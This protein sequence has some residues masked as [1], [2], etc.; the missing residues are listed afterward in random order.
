[1]HLKVSFPFSQR[2][3]GGNGS[4]QRVV[5]ISTINLSHLNLK[6][7]EN[8]DGFLRGVLKS[9]PENFKELGSMMFLSTILVK[10]HSGHPLKPFKEAI[11]QIFQSKMV[12]VV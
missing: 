7:T 4:C 12:V 5:P 6:E 10:I 8:W 3:D 1:M 2:K 11:P 9:P